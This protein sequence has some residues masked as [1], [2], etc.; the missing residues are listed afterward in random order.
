M[1]TF[2]WLLSI[3]T[4]VIGMAGT[5]LNALA[6][7]PWGFVLSALAVVGG[8]YHLDRDRLDNR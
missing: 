2:F 1:K 3:A 8:L 4:V 5:V 7:N 6:H